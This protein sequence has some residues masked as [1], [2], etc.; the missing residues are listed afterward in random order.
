VRLTYALLWSRLGRQADR[1][2]SIET[3]GALARRGIDVTLLMPQGPGDPPLA[4]ADLRAWFA[5]QGD[6]RLVQKPVRLVGEKVL[7]SA[8]W[9]RRAMASAEAAAGD[10]FYSR[11]PV[12]FAIGAGS[13]LP[14]AV[15][16][17]RPWPD[18]L[19]M[20]RPLVRRT[21]AARHCLGF[22]LHSAFAADSFRRIGVAEE[23]L[24]V[25][26]NGAEPM[27]RIGKAEARAALGLPGGRTIALYAGR[28]NARKGLDQLLLVADLR[29]E[30]LFVLVGSEGEGVV[31]REAAA[32]GNVRILPWQ[33]PEA[34]PAFL[35]AADI[36]V[37][38]PSSA[39]LSRFGDC[40]LPIKTFAY[41]AAGRPILAPRAPDTAE[42]LRHDDNAWLVPPDDPAAAAEGLKRLAGDAALAARL[43][44]SAARLA[45][46]SSWDG[47]AAKIAA[48]LEKRLVEIRNPIGPGW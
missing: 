11:I 26:H 47:R 10:L 36:L 29:P 38:P 9:L 24:L 23:K 25:A 35:Q 39:P 27:A 4:A 40:V 6:F 22:I 17:Y 5:V 18:R 8:L 41:L 12:A 30:I 13:F 44:E 19:P 31:E 14:F 21:A 34:L 32:R 2:Q 33:K 46:A 28:I 1:A 16:H 43:G 15:E 42:L 48:F 45:A 37:I 20:I 3:A 7:P